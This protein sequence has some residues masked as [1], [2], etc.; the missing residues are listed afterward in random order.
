MPRRN[1]SVL[2]QQGVY[3]GK[4]TGNWDDQTAQ[5]VQDFQSA[6]N[7]QPTGQIDGYTII[8]LMKPVQGNSDMGEGS[9]T[10]LGAMGGA[11]ATPGGT[12]VD[13]PVLGP[14]LLRIYERGYQQSFAQGLQFAQQ[15]AGQQQA[16]QQ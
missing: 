10:P 9:S 14:M 7:I 15:Q 2:K 6:N 12:V 13:H 11:N 8:A 4:P 16:G 5:A 3:D 1:R